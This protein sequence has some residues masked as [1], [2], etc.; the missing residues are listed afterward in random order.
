MVRAHGELGK[1][2]RGGWKEPQRGGYVTCGAGGWAGL[3]REM[4]SES[5]P[6]ALL[7]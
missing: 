4:V 2:Q 3:S 6:G 1:L 5:F 7:L